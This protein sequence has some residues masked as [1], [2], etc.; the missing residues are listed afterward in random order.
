ME[1][2]GRLKLLGG[3]CSGDG[4]HGSDGGHGGRHRRLGEIDSRNEALSG[5]FRLWA[6]FFLKSSKIEVKDL[7]F[8]SP[9]SLLTHSSWFRLMKSTSFSGPQTIISP[10]SWNSC[11]CL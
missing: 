3:V 5:S 9:S 2:G 1:V 8:F 4:S 7:C 10:Y 6:I 11:F